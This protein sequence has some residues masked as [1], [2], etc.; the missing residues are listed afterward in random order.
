MRTSTSPGLHRLV[1]VHQHLDHVAGD[2]G[3]DGADVPVHLRVVGRYPVAIV[4]VRDI[5]SNRPDHQ[6]Q[7]RT[8]LS[9]EADFSSGAASS[10]VSGRLTS[11]STLGI[12]KFPSIAQTA[13]PRPERLPT[14][15]TIIGLRGLI[16][17]IKNIRGIITGTALP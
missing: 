12:C 17:F 1:V 4:Q 6:Q 16:L 9:R 13:P 3:R 11:S 5:R 2:L 8:I 14:H 10:T 15:S 7:G